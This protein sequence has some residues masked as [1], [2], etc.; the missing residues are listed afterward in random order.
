MKLPPLR[1][2]PK[3][4]AG[5]LVVMLTLALALAQFGLVSVLGEQQDA[6]VEEMAHGQALAQTISL[7]RLLAVYPPSEATK[8]AGAFASRFAC[9]AVSDTA[10]APR[11][12]SKAEASLAER[13]AM[14]LH[15]V[16]SG[17]PQIAISAIGDP[18]PICVGG[19]KRDAGGIAEPDEGDRRPLS[20]HGRVATV[21]VSVPLAD[22]RWLE[23]SAAVHAPRVWNR[24]ALLSFAL[25]CLAVGAVAIVAV[26]Q[27]T[28]SLRAL[29]EASERLGRGE[30]VS[31][32]PTAGPS[33]V[34]SAARA[35][36]TMQERLG[37]FLRD[38]IRLLASI[39]HDL[40]TPLTTLRLKAEFIEDEAVRD[41][42]V[43]TID[44]MTVICEATLAFTK[45][46]TTSEATETTDLSQLA[47]TV[48][49]E[50]RLR[51]DDVF[52]SPSAPVLGACRP[53]ALKRAVRNLIENAVR[54]G[55]NAHVSVRR[56]RDAAVI[57]IEDD[58]PGIA[59]EKIEEAFKPFVR[60]EES[61]SAETGGMGLGLSIARSV[62]IAHGGSLTLA[63]RPEGGIRAEIRL[64]AAKA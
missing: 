61:R 39:S 27:Q 18:A 21:T 24:I 14:M 64:P 41:D 22:G 50:F 31:P 23:M 52:V 19:W 8:L 32:V 9:A 17:P 10:P 36:N 13:V 2:W 28:R 7:A 45:A 53:V 6:V 4:L 37:E 11:P 34:A 55:G 57:A 48:A 26:R 1:L 25:S 46:E 59:A 49:E 3:S 12:M 16:N 5:R 51:S 35:F 44:E 42:V 40:R 62:A 29:A 60:L 30:R 20:D 56:D 58:G 54:Y 15:G 43:A 47:G 38:R 33:E 63:N